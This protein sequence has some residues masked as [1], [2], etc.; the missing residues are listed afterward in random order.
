MDR[1]TLTLSGDPVPL[2]SDIALF[3]PGFHGSFW[4]SASG[5]LLAYRTEASDKPRL[6]WIHPDGKR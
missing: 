2:A 1:R 4:S 5:N 3:P 6:T